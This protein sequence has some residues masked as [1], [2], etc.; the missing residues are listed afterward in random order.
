MESRIPHIALNFLKNRTN[1]GLGEKLSPVFKCGCLRSEEPEEAMFETG[2]SLSPNPKFV[3][4]LRK[5]KAT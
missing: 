3:L 5:F 1:F 2:Q 4:F